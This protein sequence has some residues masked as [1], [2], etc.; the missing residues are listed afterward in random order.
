[1]SKES[2]SLNSQIEWVQAY[3]EAL[4]QQRQR[5]ERLLTILRNSQQVLDQWTTQY[6]GLLEMKQELGLK[7]ISLSQN[8]RESLEEVLGSRA[9]EEYYNLIDESILQLVLE[10]RILTIA[11]METAL[12]KIDALIVELI[13]CA[14]RIRQGEKEAIHD[15]RDLIRK[16]VVPICF[17]LALIGADVPLQSWPTVIGGGY[18]IYRA[19]IA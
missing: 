10:R 2:T 15:T 16:K 4:K 6:L 14:N 11:E 5:F 9:L 7:L 12:A 17:G 19:S 8:E 3:I 18:I 13:A 1:M